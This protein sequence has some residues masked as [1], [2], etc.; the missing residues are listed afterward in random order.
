M[1]KDEKSD[2]FSINLSNLQLQRGPLKCCIMDNLCD[3]IVLHYGLLD[4]CDSENHCVIEIKLLYAPDLQ[5][6]CISTTISFFF[7]FDMPRL[8]LEVKDKI[9]L[10]ENYFVNISFL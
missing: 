1:I 6:N 4:F 5:T 9:L 7:L 10:P 3:F 2:E 8:V